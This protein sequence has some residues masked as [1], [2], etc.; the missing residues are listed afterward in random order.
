MKIKTS[1][2]ILFILLVL[3]SFGQDD[4]IKNNPLTITLGSSED[5]ILSLQEIQKTP[6]LHA[7]YKNSINEIEFN[8]ISFKL[9]TINSE[10]K[11]ETTFNL[12]FGNELTIEQLNHIKKMNTGDKLTFYDIK[13]TC[14]DCAIRTLNPLTIII[15]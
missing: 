12:T 7:N 1:I 14:K 5:T 9:T 2:T 15:K 11:K 4:S 8:I 3:I 10:T 13:T 6:N